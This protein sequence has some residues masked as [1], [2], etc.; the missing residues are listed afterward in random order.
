MIWSLWQL[1]VSWYKNK[2][3][4]KRFTCKPCFCFFYLIF[5]QNYL[6]E[7][8]EFGIWNFWNH[9]LSNLHFSIEFCTFLNK[10]GL[11]T[12]FFNTVFAI[13]WC[14]AWR[15][16]CSTLL[17]PMFKESTFFRPQNLAWRTETFFKHKTI[18]SFE[19]GLLG[20]ALFQQLKSSI[21]ITD[22][23]RVGPSNMTC[24]IKEL[25]P[26]SSNPM[27]KIRL[28]LLLIFVEQLT[29]C[30]HKLQISKSGCFN[31]KI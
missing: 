1:W 30:F 26:L 5:Y 16:S 3:F 19:I 4:W 31:E 8:S 9:V 12:N 27:K 2:C 29:T 28:L 17:I 15:V 23:V 20:E 18:C 22:L 10:L 13:F 25:F 6:I 14:A 7:N 24:L 21:I 11:F